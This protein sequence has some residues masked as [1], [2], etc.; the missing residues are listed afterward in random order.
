M[1]MWEFSMSGLG[2]ADSKKPPGAEG[3]REAY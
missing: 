1:A 3:R 2:E